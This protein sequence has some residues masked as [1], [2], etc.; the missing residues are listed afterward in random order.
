MKQNLEKLAKKMQDLFPDDGKIQ[1]LFYEYKK[2]ISEWWDYYGKYDS[3]DLLD[4]FFLIYSYKETKNFDFG[5]QLIDNL[6]Y[7]NLFSPISKEDWVEC[8][9]CEGYGEVICHVCGGDEIIDCPE[10]DGSG[11]DSEGEPCEFCNGDG[12][13]DCYQC[14]NGKERCEN[15]YGEGEIMLDD[16]IKALDIQIIVWGKQFK[17][18]LELRCG[19]NDVISEDADIFFKEQ[20]GNFIYLH[21]KEIHM[22]KENY[23]EEG[24]LRCNLY[25]ENIPD[26]FL[27]L[28]LKF[29]L[30]K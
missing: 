22:Y 29:Y 20:E 6:S 15:C 3:Q 1:S 2:I 12:G 27:G 23:Y 14:E 21:T 8:S 4:L 24:E 7:A 28:P 18:I 13:V 25:K 9:E 16:S 11:H 17:D 26:S 5:Y 19:T 30:K 10:C